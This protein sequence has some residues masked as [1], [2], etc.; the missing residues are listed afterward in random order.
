MIEYNVNEPN[1]LDVNEVLSFLKETDDLV[2]PSMSSL[3]DLDE[4][5]HKI[6]SK[7]V[8]F[9][10]RDENCI[11]GLTAIYFNKAPDYSYSTYMM[12]KREY[13]LVEM[14]GMELSN[15]VRDYAK[16]N[17]SAGLRYEIRKSNKPLLRYHLRRGAKIVSEQVYPGTDIVSLL[18]EITY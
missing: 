15:R 10:A 7:A 18:M 17:G 5:A 9:T 1:T 12:V 6:T 11:I 2:V 14:V 8:I 4:Y 13:Q 3:C 16:G